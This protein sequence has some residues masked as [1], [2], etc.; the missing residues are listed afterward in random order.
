MSL[1]LALLLGAAT[2]AEPSVIPNLTFRTGTLAH[3][4]GKGFVPTCAGRSGPSLDWA[5]ISSDA[6]EA[7]RSAVLHRTFRVPD[8]VVAIRFRAAAVRRRGLAPGERLDVVLEAPPHRVI[9][10]RV[11]S[12]SDWQRADVL[13]SKL[14]GRLREYEWNVEGLAG[15]YVRIAIMD[16]DERAGCHVVCSGFRLIAREVVRADDGL[17]TFENHMNKLAKEH[18]LTPMERVES[19][20]FVAL[21]NAPDDYTDHRL[22]NCET[23]YPV[24]FEHFR[25]K[26]FSVKEPP[27]KLMVAIF[28]TQSGFDAYLGR[29]MPPTVAGIYHPPSNRLVVYDLGTNPAFVEQIERGRQQVN[30]I[31]TELDRRRIIGAFNRSV[32]NWRNDANLSTVMHETAHLLS[33]NCGLLNREG[34]VPAWL[35]EGLACY[36]EGTDSGAWQG[37][38]ESNPA[39]AGSFARLLKAKGTLIPL[40]ELVSS[41]NWLRRATSAEQVLLGYAQSWALFRLLMEERP[42]A[43]R[44]YLAAVYTR[45]VPEHRLTDFGEAFGADLAKLESRY[46]EYVAELARS[47]ARPG[48]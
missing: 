19:E 3:W 38:G 31:K 32:H 18:Q 20:H 30:K 11:R 40:K 35:A 2:P 28:D 21:S 37:V 1:A 47:Q 39:R 8:N 43:M 36:C 45:R 22:Y 42:A 5:V 14:D 24:F 7:G 23:I 16:L 44:K 13:L 46:Q 25:R 15:Q 4:E 9:P 27:G 17:R 29:K 10:K 34:D 48:R 33:F 6:G 26:G 41:D 12:G